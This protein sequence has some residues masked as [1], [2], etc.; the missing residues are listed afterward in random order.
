[1]PRENDH[2]KLVATAC[3]GF[4]KRIVTEIRAVLYRRVPNLNVKIIPLKKSK[5][6]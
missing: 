2:G 1:M 5:F 6:S 4:T 3:H